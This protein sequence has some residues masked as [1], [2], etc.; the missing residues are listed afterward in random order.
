MVWHIKERLNCSLKK[1]GV[2]DNRVVDVKGCVE[3]ENNEKKG[4]GPHLKL[5]TPPNLGLSLHKFTRQ[6]RSKLAN[7]MNIKCTY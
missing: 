7:Q 1:V 3:E 5:T 6:A 4:W 2:V